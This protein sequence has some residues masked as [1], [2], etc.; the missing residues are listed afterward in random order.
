MDLAVANIF[1]NAKLFL[2]K[3]Q[4][5]EL[6]AMIMQEA[7][8]PEKV[9]KRVSNVPTMEE[10]YEWALATLVNGS[11]TKMRGKSVRRLTLKKEEKVRDLAIAHPKQRKLK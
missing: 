7:G 5:Q 2:S 3:E 9:T 1:N 10:Y 8:A 4:L 11:K 6:G